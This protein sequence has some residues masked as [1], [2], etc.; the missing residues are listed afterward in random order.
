M[1]EVEPGSTTGIPYQRSAFGSTRLIVPVDVLLN[2]APQLY[3]ADFYCM[4]GRFHYI[5]LVMTRPRSTADDFCREHLLPLS[6][7]DEQNNPFLFRRAGTV[8]MRVAEGVKV[9]VL[10]TENIDVNDMRRRLGATIVE[11]IPLIGKG[12]STPG[13]LRKNPYCHVCNLRPPYVDLFTS[14][15]F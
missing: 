3:F 10:F 2:M 13:G 6:I 5:T 11:N 12:S 14:D 4:R 15:T 7:Y 8:E 1:A 9:E